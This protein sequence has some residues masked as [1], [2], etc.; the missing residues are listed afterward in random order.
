MASQTSQLASLMA[1]TV[2]PAPSRHPTLPSPAERPGADVVIYDGQCGFCRAQVARLA[3][4]DHREQLAFLPLQDPGIAELYPDLTE[5][6]L[7]KEMVLVDSSG[8]RHGGA[9]AFRYLSRKL[10]RLWW[11]APIMHVPWTMPLWQSIYQL[12]ARH[13]YRLWAR[14]NSCDSGSCRLP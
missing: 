12:I 5:D 9:A 11:L 7:F 13:R 10:P 4:W 3:R 14:D 1:T 8:H 2:T 6:R